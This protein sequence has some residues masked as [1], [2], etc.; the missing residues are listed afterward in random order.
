MGR[1][2]SSLRGNALLDHNS[3][4]ASWSRR[5]PHEGGG[6]L[7]QQRISVQWLPPRMYFTLS[8]VLSKYFS[9]GP[10][11]FTASCQLVILIWHPEVVMTRCSKQL[12]PELCSKCQSSA[13]FAR[14]FVWNWLVPLFA[15]RLK[16]AA[17][18]VKCDILARS[19][20]LLG[21]KA[22]ARNQEGGAQG[23]TNSVT[24][25]LPKTEGY[26]WE[27]KHNSCFREAIIQKI[28]VFFLCQ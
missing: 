19:R 10:P 27:I 9:F 12:K 21:D 22:S 8:D 16:K 4:L 13:G 20:S 11:I 17:K 23:R 15:W 25:I 1:T 7:S 26:F 28:I 2:G 14:F 3:L 18:T 24:Q 5:G 6:G